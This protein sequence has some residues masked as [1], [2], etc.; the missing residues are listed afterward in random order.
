MGSMRRKAPTLFVCVF[1]VYGIAESR[2]DDELIGGAVYVC[3]S[4]P[5]QIDSIDKACLRGAKSKGEVAVYIH[6]AGFVGGVFVSGSK[7]RFVCRCD[8][9]D[10]VTISFIVW[11]TQKR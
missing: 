7:W 11:M 8:L 4:W 10:G 2:S 5:A 6:G 3:P 9:W 1:M